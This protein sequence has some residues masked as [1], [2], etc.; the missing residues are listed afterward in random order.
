MFFLLLRMP[1]PLKLSDIRGQ[2]GDQVQLDRVPHDPFRVWKE[3]GSAT[4][5]KLDEVKAKM[6][7]KEVDSVTLL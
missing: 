4:V 5:L 2:G 7:K 1:T 6:Q 3:L